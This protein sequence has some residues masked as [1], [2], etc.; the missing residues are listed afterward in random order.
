[1]I[2]STV[3]TFL[4]TDIE[5]STQ[6]WEQHPEAM[7]TALARHDAILR[8]AIETQRGSVF[9]TVG[10]AF[11]AAFSNV[12]QALAAALVAQR[13]LAAETWDETPIKVRMAIHAGAVET[14]DDDYFGPPL[15]RVA[16]LLASGH[17]GQTL[18]SATA[19]ELVQN[20]LPQG[21]S[22]RDMGERRLKD[23]T[24]PEHIYQLLVPDLP[25]D[26]PPLKTL[27]GL[28]TNLP[29]QLTS[30]VGREKEI[31]AL[32]RL[33][34]TNRLTTLTG[35]GGAG[36]TRLSLQV[37]VDLLDTFPDGVWFVEF[38][39]LADPAL[40]PQTVM[41][42]L[43]LREESGRP[44]FD[45]LSGYLRPKTALLILDNCEHLV[46]ASAQLVEALLQ[47]CPNLRIL[48]SSREALGIPGESAYRVP[49]LS[50]PDTRHIPSIEALTQYEAVRLFIDRAQSALPTFVVTKENAPAV[51]QVCARLDG[52]PLAIELAAARVKMLKVE[53]IAERLDD[54]F[55]LL[56]G[57]SRTALPRQ[58]TLRAM[59]DWSY[60]LLPEPERALLRRLSVFA[61]GWTLEAAETVCQ[62]P[63]IEDYNVLDPLTRLVDKSLVVVEADDN[64][65]T[66]YRLL[67]TVRQYVREKL[68][69]AGEGVAM[70]DA[71]LQYFLGLAER[72]EPELNGP[73]VMEW[74]Q[75]LEAELDN[76]RAALEWS[77]KQDAQ[78]GLRLAY[79]LN[80][81][82]WEAGY[83]RDLRDWL[84]QLLKQPEAQSHTVISARTLGI[85][86][87]LDMSRSLI[88]KSIALCRE[89]GDKQGLAI[90]LSRLGNVVLEQDNE[91][92]QH[93]LEESLMV[94]QELGDKQ[95]SAFA[96]AALGAVA[97]ATNKENEQARIY[98][99][100]GLA[101]FREIENLLGVIVS[102]ANLG[103]LAVRQGDYDAA[104]RWLDELLTLENQIGKRGESI[105]SNLHVLGELALRKG[106][107]NQAFIYY[108][109]GLST[110]QKTGQ[111]SW[112][113]KWILANLGYISLQQGDILL[114]RNFFKESIEVSKQV[115]S[116]I[117]LV[118]ALEGLASLATGE[119]QFKQAVQIF[120]FADSARE[121]IGDT[122]PA[123]EQANVD[124]DLAT[125]HAQLDE[126]AFAAAQA[127][128]RAMSMEQ[129]I[130]YALQVGNH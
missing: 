113:S 110:I 41:T 74:L 118:Y 53:Q 87:S 85:L 95:N 63:G 75:R 99:E 30:F 72:A 54:R 104:R 33:I 23:L 58:Q 9:K 49:S 90:G 35:S 108:E 98:S 31:A 97:G 117:G 65:E 130:E 69:E 34:S 22:L 109:R 112:A 71:H 38:A 115:G 60:D 55:R 21:S 81:F 7:Q 93:L 128:G 16:R 57:G 125:I 77:L 18:L 79:K 129:A 123:N 111:S 37:A 124:R 105:I 28:R 76:I 50:I 51:A 20:H 66:R 91:H 32:K 100:K 14:R 101:I 36:K 62:G 116:K 94:S 10:D 80:L 3:V 11:Y 56:T 44:V 127:A 47:A 4:F 52:I 2:N 73:R 106:D 89:L 27:E 59:I 24:R 6:L 12:S 45:S 61:G 8:Q 103:R 48:V 67:E 40:V 43:G 122:R 26:F 119:G 82:W 42:T 68:T 78:I 5:G 96:L 19:H 64:A 126:A 46:E 29:A 13:A 1:M 17:G 39:P 70:R 84:I 88:E 86:G 107:Y 83:N 25:A 121:M 120:A 102:L 15:N 114:A 92:A